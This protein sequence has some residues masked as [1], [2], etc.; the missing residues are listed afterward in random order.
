MKI[1]LKDPLFLSALPVLN[2]IASEG[3]EAYFVGGC[4]R[5]TLLNKPIHDIDIASS[6]RPEEIESIFPNTIDIGK[7]HGTIIVVYHHAAYEVTT[8]RVESDYSDFRRPDS[9]DFIRNLKEDTL[10]RD[11][12]INALA[13]NHLGQV[14]DYHGG[15][16]DLNAGII[17]AVGNP[18]SRFQEDALRMVRAIRFASQLGF[19]IES[20]TF[21]A[22]QDQAH[23][24]DKIAIE[25]VRIEMTKYFMGQYFQ[26]AGNLLCDTGIAQSLPILRGKAV[27]AGIHALQGHTLFNKNLPESIYWYYFCSG[28]GLLK[29]EVATY[30]RKWSHSNQVIVEVLA[31][32]DLDHRVKGQ[33]LDAWTVYA[34]PLDLIQA[35]ELVYDQEK[36]LGQIISNQ[37][38][39]H[40]RQEMMTDGKELMGWLGLKKGNAQLG[41]LIQKMERALVEGE[42]SNNPVELKSFALKNWKK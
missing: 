23:L 9:V 8:F 41:H 31:L 33:T 35:L 38:P 26:E 1:K 3:Y 2:K 4:V 36:S 32:Y 18:A 28:M 20:N 14:F 27:E 30:L 24:L 10:R 16:D 12:T 25:R 19:E 15:Q 42:I 40:S 7:E 37:L 11:F 29:S 22:I 34:Y 5:D 13:L 21:Q 6:A 39:I 17:R